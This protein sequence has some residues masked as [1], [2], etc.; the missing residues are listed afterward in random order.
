DRDVRPIFAEHCLECHSMDKAKGGLAL[1]TREHAMK[2]LKSGHVALVPG[3][4]DASEIIA[5]MT[6][7]D[8]DEMM[9][10]REHREKKP[11]TGKEV[12]TLKA[13]ISGGGEWPVHWAY[14]PI[15]KAAL[16]Q[17]E[18]DPAGAGLK[19][20]APPDASRENATANPKS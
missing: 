13:W 2:K 19:L 8:E 17:V 10:P 15:V 11:L 5:R 3:K 6:S 12:E 9:P 7:A 4:P 16:P 18:A 1:V 20:S 14:R